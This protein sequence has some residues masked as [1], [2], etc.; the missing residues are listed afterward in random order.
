MG[1]IPQLRSNE[2][3]VPWNPRV[4]DGFSYCDF[5][6]VYT[7]SVDMSVTSLECRANCLFLGVGILDAMSELGRYIYSITSSA[8]A[9]FQTQLLELKHPC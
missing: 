4:L 1:V 7:R 9:M 3:L 5:G 6:T 8:P 2:Y